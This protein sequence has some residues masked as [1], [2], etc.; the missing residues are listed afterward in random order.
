MDLKLLAG[1]GAALAAAIWFVGTLQE[2]QVVASVEGAQAVAT[3]P[4]G[5]DRLM[6]AANRAV[7]G[8]GGGGGMGQSQDGSRAILDGRVNGPAHRILAG[9]R[10]GASG[11]LPSR[12]EELEVPDT[13]DVRRPG[14]GDRVHSV[15]A[16]RADASVPLV[17]LGSD[18]LDYDLRLVLRK[19][20]AGRPYE[21][22]NPPANRA[23]R[24]QDV[25]VT[26]TDGSVFLVLQSDQPNLIW[27]LHIAERARLAGIALVGGR[28]IGLV[29]LPDEVPVSVWTDARL[30]RCG[31][32]V[33]FPPPADHVI[34]RS[35][36]MENR[37]AEV[38]LVAWQ[39]R[40]RAWAEWVDQSFG[41]SAVRGPLEDS[42]ASLH[43]VGPEP[44][45]ALPFVPL[46]GAVLRLTPAQHLLAGDDW[47]AAYQTLVLTEAARIAG[48]DL[49][50]L[51]PQT[52]TGA[53]SE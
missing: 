14:A 42:V 22:S 31:V 27:S 33:S 48:T 2:E 36:Q 3:P 1:A 38:S 23:F 29:H 35:V 45:R 52:L 24:L 49:G 41:V 8:A 16:S 18:D 47:R 51:A 46:A 44:V 15:V 19:A 6:S 25:A 11:D 37:E 7:L 10:S 4:S 20:K 50:A 40:D 21:V 17:P 5:L 39:A 32:A 12:V 43:L 53:A 28:H 30:A 13:C 26:D 9:Y 34:R